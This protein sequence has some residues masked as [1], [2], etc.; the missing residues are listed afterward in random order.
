[1]QSKP[2]VVGLVSGSG[3][4][5]ARTWAA[6]EPNTGCKGEE[7]GA[8]YRPFQ[9]SLSIRRKLRLLPMVETKR[10]PELLLPSSWAREENFYVKLIVP[11]TAPHALLMD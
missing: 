5:A 4:S 3:L 2:A 11:A 8:A 9:K 6:R 7:C 1:M 10:I